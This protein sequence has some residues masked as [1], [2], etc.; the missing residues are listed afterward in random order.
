MATEMRTQQQ[1]YLRLAAAGVN[2]FVPSGDAGSNPDSTG[3]SSDGP[4]QGGYPASDPAD[5]VFLS[6][7]GKP[8]PGDLGGTSW[9]APCWAGFCALINEPRTKAGKL[10][11]TLLNPLYPLLGT[12]CIRDMVSGTNGA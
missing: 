8:F 2:V 1:K 7:N 6:L 10:A 3:Q 9:G 11:V 4:L 5:G 12:T